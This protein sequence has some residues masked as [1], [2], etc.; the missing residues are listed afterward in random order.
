MQRLDRRAG[1]RPA[2]RPASR[3]NHSSTTSTAKPRF[4][5]ARI[6]RRQEA[7]RT[8]GGAATC[9][10]RSRTLNLAGSRCGELDD[11]AVEVRHAHLQAVRHRQLVGV[12]QQFVGQRRADLEHLEAA[13]LVGAVH[14]GHE[15]APAVETP[16]PAPAGSTPVAEQAVDLV[17][18]HER[19]DVA[20]S[21]RRRSSTSERVDAALERLVARQPLDAGAR[22]SAA[23]TPGSARQCAPYCTPRWRV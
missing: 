20:G 4:L 9:A 16:S 1:S 19:E 22:A 13:E 2:C 23:A 12:H 3:W 8:P 7:A 21:A 10:G 15:L 5:R 11:L 18:R 6:S 14:L 17:A